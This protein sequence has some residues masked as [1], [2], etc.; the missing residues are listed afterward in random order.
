ML[1]YLTNG[2]GTDDHDSEAAWRASCRTWRMRMQTPRRAEPNPRSALPD[3]KIAERMCDLGAAAALLVRQTDICV[4]VLS[5]SEEAIRRLP[6]PCDVSDAQ[7]RLA[8]SMWASLLRT[9]RP[10]LVQHPS[11]PLTLDSV[12]GGAATG[13]RDGGR[14]L[15]VVLSR[16]DATLRPLLRLLPA[17]LDPPCSTSP[18]RPSAV[19]RRAPGRLRVFVYERCMAVAAHDAGS[20]ALDVRHRLFS[21][22]RTAATPPAATH[23]AAGAERRADR[24]ADLSVTRTV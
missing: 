17:L 16:C 3:E 9:Y 23:S 12:I 11:L 13:R 1:L 24:T 20:R 22:H 5:C 18:T 7:L 19:A 14:S 21:L 15:D 4:S 8:Q 2:L 10:I 6:A